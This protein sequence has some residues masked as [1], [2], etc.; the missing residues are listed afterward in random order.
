[1]KYLTLILGLLFMGNVHANQCLLSNV[2]YLY[3]PFIGDA[4]PAGR[5]HIN[6]TLGRLSAHFS[7]SWTLTSAHQVVLFYKAGP[8]HSSGKYYNSNLSGIELEISEDNDEQ[9][10]GT[11]GVNTNALIFDKSVQDEAFSY[12]RWVFLVNKVGEVPKDTPSPYLLGPKVF[13][14]LYCAFLDSSGAVL[15][16]ELLTSA[17]SY[18]EVDITYPTCSIKTASEDQTVS[19]EPVYRSRLDSIG[20]TYGK[21]SFDMTL[22]CEEGVIT[23]A[24]VSDANGSSNNQSLLNTGSAKGVALQ[25]LYNDLPVQLGDSFYV[26]GTNS[27]PEGEYVIRFDVQYIREGGELTS[28]DVASKAII[29]F[30]YR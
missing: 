26:S 28:G 24:T 19:L 3:T 4:I 7:V 27:S 17:F 20:A 29:S 9:E 5:K 6:E 30:S 25:V 15:K 13:E 2:N 14:G 11:V 22:Q 8:S 18:S 10:Q 21:T 1:M 23:D 16:E 12:Q